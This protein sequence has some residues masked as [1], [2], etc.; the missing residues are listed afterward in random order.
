[1]LDAALLTALLDSLND[2]FTF[3][4]TEH[5]VRY[6]NPAAIAH[7][8]EGAALLGRSVLDCHNADSQ[9]QIEEITAAFQAGET[10]RLITDNEKHRIYMRAVRDPAGK[11]LGYY[12]RYEPPVAPEVRVRLGQP[13]T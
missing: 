2:P 12:E 3:A 1:M 11:L 5:V 8:K 7:Y 9:R 10:E 4:D 13:T 6:M